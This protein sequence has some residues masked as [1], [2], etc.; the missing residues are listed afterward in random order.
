M[1]RISLTLCLL[2]ELCESFASLRETRITMRGSRKD[3]KNRKGRK[4]L[5]SAPK[6]NLPF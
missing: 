3:A 5:T 2:S 4:E 1:E 6:H